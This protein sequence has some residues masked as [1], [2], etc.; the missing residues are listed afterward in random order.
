MMSGLNQ[1]TQSNMTPPPIPKPLYNVVVNGQ[2]AG[3]YDVI[4]LRQMVSAGNINSGSLVW[5]AGM[6]EWEKAGNVEELK[7][8]FN[9]TPPPIPNV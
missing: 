5:T 1:Q 2:S 4:T 8:L 3:P 9:M 6:A 7:N